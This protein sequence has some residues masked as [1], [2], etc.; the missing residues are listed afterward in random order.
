MLDDAVSGHSGFGSG[1]DYTTLMRQN[2]K[3]TLI[4]YGTTG[5]FEI[6]NY[7]SDEIH[8]ITNNNERVTI[9]ADGTVGIGVTPETDFRTSNVQGLQVGAGGS[10]FARKDAGETKI[11][12]AENVKWTSDG[13]EYINNAPAA[14]HGMDAGIHSFVV[15]SSGTADAVISET[16]ALS[17][18]NS[19]DVTFPAA[20]QKISG[21]STSTGSF[22]MGNFADKLGIGNTAPVSDNSLAAFIH[23]GSSA[24]GRA[25]IA[26]QDNENK[27]EI[28]T[29]DSA[30]KFSDGTTERM[31]LDNNGRLGIGTTSPDFKLQV[32]GTIAPESD[33]SS[34]LGSA[35]LR[36]ADV[37]AVQT[38]TG[39]V[40][41]T[42][43]KTEKIGDNPTGTIV[44]WREDGLVPCDSNEDELVMGVIK[45]GKDEPI[46]LGA[47]PVLVTGKV[48]VGD[49]IVT[50]DKIGHGKA[51]KRGYLLKKDL[52]GKVIAQALE[53]SDDSDSC[54]IKCMIRKM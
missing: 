33:N 21:S 11:F 5:G 2:G 19:G 18:A 7:S 8:F 16:L 25:G 26:L 48:D 23:V 30:L 9:G 54:L 10:I 3:T 49:Y 22:A 35:S 51:V 32:D 39:G 13:F 28:F 52:F 1:A 4:A 45:E 53:P 47:E 40:F 38:T 31:R 20:N 34:N 15:A 50:S 41:E 6:G 43:L 17:I 27:F 44:S 36:W 46:V 24:A 29:T 42:G 14:Y 37:F 12:I